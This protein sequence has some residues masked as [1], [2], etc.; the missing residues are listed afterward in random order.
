ME[1]GFT[2]MA[3]HHLRS[4]SPWLISTTLA[5]LIGVPA[6]A[7]QPLPSRPTP[8]SSSLQATA[9]P[10]EIKIPDEVLSWVDE[11]ISA[12]QN[13]DAAEALQLQLKVMEWANARLDPAHPFRARVLNN[14]SAFLS[15]V[16]R[17][18]EAL[19][20]S[21][22]AVAFRRIHAKNDPA[23][24][25]DLGLALFTLGTLLGDM[26]RQQE[27]LAATT[28][29]VHIFSN[30]AKTNPLVKANLADAL[31]NQG[32]ALRE[33][34][35]HEEALASTEKAVTHYRELAKTNPAYLVDLS[36]ALNNLGAYNND[37]GSARS[38]PARPV[39]SRQDESCKEQ[40]TESS[41]SSGRLLGQ[42]GKHLWPHGPVEGV[43][44]I[45]R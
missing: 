15:A 44:H 17:R 9:K 20:L 33:L 42:L 35:R 11:A 32:M 34:D 38:S 39:G 24:L 40:R 4:R 10:E 3:A 19:S 6:Q 45:H 22:E 14:L 1:K 29:S 25:P 28:E 36:S 2:S 41:C 13:G 30:L 21:K 18:E 37:L 27:A 16:G 7:L 12:Y 31:I 5:L 23:Y 43:P 26:G 8:S